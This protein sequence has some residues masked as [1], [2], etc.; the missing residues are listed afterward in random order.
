[1]ANQSLQPVFDDDTVF[2][3]EWN[4]IRD[5]SNGHQFQKRFGHTLRLLGRPGEFLLI[6]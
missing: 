5:G 4:H 6:Y 3:R 1:M 2:A